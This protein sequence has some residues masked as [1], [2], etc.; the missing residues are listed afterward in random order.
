MKIKSDFV[1]NSSSSS[2]VVI[3]PKEIKF[4]DDILPYMED[5]KAHIVYSDALNQTPIQIKL[6]GKGT[7]VRVHIFDK[8]Y[9]ILQN[10]LDD[11]Y[12]NI[13]QISTEITEA[14]EKECPGIM[15]PMTDLDYFVSKIKRLNPDAYERLDV[16]PDEIKELINKANNKGFLYYFQYSDECGQNELEHGGTFDR[17]P[18][19]QISHH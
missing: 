2:F 16:E 17:L 6:G 1:T 5:W 19:I 18:H 14:I 11:M 12:I 3:F 9:S 13:V 8:I 15:V 4:I 7:E 10:N